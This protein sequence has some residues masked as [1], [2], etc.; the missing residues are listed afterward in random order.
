MLPTKQNRTYL[1]LLGMAVILLSG[2]ARAQ[3]VDA[4]FR[5]TF[6]PIQEV[7]VTMGRSTPDSSISGTETALRSGAKASSLLIKRP[8]V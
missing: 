8:A 5:V 6:D 4:N 3:G 1:L 2:L 7:H